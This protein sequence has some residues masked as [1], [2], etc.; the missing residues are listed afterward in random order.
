MD[1]RHL[2]PNK[3]YRGEYP[4]LGAGKV[5]FEKQKT[6]INA[7]DEYRQHL[8]SYLS[9]YRGH[10]S[11]HVVGILDPKVCYRADGTAFDPRPCTG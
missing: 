10:G 1:H 3:Q 5:F 8:W 9:T 2:V 4:L 11:A 6:C 7:N